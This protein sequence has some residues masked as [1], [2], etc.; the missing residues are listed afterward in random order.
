M[1]RGPKT[2]RALVFADRQGAELAPLTENLPL[3]LLPLG[4]KEVLVHC[5]EDLIQAGIR[6]VVIVVSAHADQIEAALGDGRRWG[7]R[8][9]YVL[10]RGEEDPLAI[11][12]RLNLGEDQPLLAL[13]GDVLRTP[14]VAAFLELVQGAA[15]L[16][17]SAAWGDPRGGLVWLGPSLGLTVNPVQ[18]GS[19]DGAEPVAAPELL[20]KLHW[21]ASA[22]SAPDHALSPLTGVIHL[23]GTRVNLLA[24]IVD[25]H[26]AN[27]DLVAGRLPGVTL[28][29]RMSAL[30]LTLGPRARVS[31][32]SL[33]QGVAF[34]GANSRIHPEAEL[35]GEVVIGE[36]VVVDRGA[37]IRDS[38]I[39]SQTY[40][41][42]WL[43]VTNAVVA[44]NL[45]VRVDTG[46]VLR[47]SDAFLLGNLAEGGGDGALA[48]GFDRFLGLWLLALSLPLWPLA[49][50]M[51][52]L[53]ARAGPLMAAGEYWGHRR[54][55]LSVSGDAARPLTLRHWQTAI[56]VL[57]KLPWLLA[58]VRGDLRLVGVSPL[59]PAESG[60]RSEDWQFV[61]DGAPVGL[62]GPTQFS[63]PDHAPIEER[64]L[65]DAFYARQRTWLRDKAFLWQGLKLLFS[66]EA[67]QRPD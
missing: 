34:V 47:I 40:V 4:G 27:R 64:L 58:V 10:S 16:T 2:M 36:E 1:N 54:P 44:P 5:V 41:G 59:T 67:W 6:E 50:L 29:G 46:A 31:P 42:E 22:A 66:A 39:L 23:E 25:Y 17:L 26:R 48:R 8:F 53:E 35:L 18:G 45:L 37:T 20:S 52:A 21:A 51:A 61:R 30:G 55:H 28:P 38:V 56:P 12:R 11:W 19:S 13:R 33:K 9:R 14:V 24:S 65:S 60:A 43:E 15:R 62:F 57:R 3:A 7:G 63:L 32:K 49:A